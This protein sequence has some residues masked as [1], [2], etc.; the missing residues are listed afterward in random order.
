MIDFDEEVS[1]FEM[2]QETDS[3]EENIL[4]SDIKDL[5]DLL[6]QFLGGY[7]YEQ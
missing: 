3:V 4:K 6:E 1:K 7:Q 5:A 2:S